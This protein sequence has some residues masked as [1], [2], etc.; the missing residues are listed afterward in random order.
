MTAFSTERSALKKKG[1]LFAVYLEGDDIT[2]E[3]LSR[4]SLVI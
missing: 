3:I 4:A 1:L 2:Q